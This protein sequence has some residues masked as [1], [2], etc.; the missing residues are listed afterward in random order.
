M[1]ARQDRTIET[2]KES[3]RAARQRRMS[4]IGIVLTVLTSSCSPGQTELA[5]T[6][7]PARGTALEIPVEPFTGWQHFFAAL[8]TAGPASWS[9]NRVQRSRFGPH[10]GPTVPVRTAIVRTAD[11][12]DAIDVGGVVQ[13]RTTAA[14]AA[15]LVAPLLEV[16]V[17]P[18]DR[19]HAGQL[20]AV[21]DGRDLQAQARAAAAASAAALDGVAAARAEE[22]AARAASVLARASYERIEALHAKQSATSQELDQAIAAFEAAESHR[23][24]AAARVREA[25]AGVDRAAASRDAAAAT[26][27]FL[28]LTAPF[29][30]LVTQK[31]VDPGN[32]VTPGQALLRVEDTR[33]FHVELRVDES[34]ANR[35]VPG[36]TVDVALDGDQVCIPGTVTEVSRAVDT[37]E[38]ASLVKVALADAPRTLRSGAFARVRIPGASRKALTVPAEAVVTQGQVSSVFVVEEGTARLRLIR[39]RDRE[40]LAGLSEGDEVIVGPPPHLV[41]GLAVTTEN[42]Q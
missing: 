17:L 32:I 26:E 10:S 1:K 2:I 30:G 22:Q 25:A 13:A 35:L 27:S 28:R 6:I 5:A 3:R 31:L 15:R 8:R 39:L 12:N 9:T 20:V 7:G 40:V 29:D 34:R 36:L 42:G 41:D 37:D 16:R 38:R 14:V 21:L 24:A 18:G 23:T 4:W 11:I 33:S 19:V